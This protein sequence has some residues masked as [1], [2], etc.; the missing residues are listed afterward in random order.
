MRHECLASGSDVIDKYEVLC[1]DVKL[2][3]GLRR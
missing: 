2:S 1:R 3:T